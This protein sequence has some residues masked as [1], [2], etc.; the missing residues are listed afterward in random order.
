MYHG[1]LAAV[2][3]VRA[4]RVAATGRDGGDGQSIRIDGEGS[5]DGAIGLYVGEGIGGYCAY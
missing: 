4:G 3:G 2:I 5:V 1:I